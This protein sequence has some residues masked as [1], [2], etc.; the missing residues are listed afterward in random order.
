MALIYGVPGDQGSI[1]ILAVVLFVLFAVTNISSRYDESR[2][3][4]VLRF[5][6]LAELGLAHQSKRF[7]HWLSSSLLRCNFSF[8]SSFFKNSFLSFL[9]SKAPSRLSGGV[10]P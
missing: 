1:E 9:Y 7:F 6:T 8:F 10:I 5:L 2:L 3:E 4:E